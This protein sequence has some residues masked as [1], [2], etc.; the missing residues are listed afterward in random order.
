MIWRSSSLQFFEILCKGDEFSQRVE[1]LPLDVT[2]VLRIS[3]SVDAVKLLLVGH[4]HVS[5]QALDGDDIVLKKFSR[6]L[7][8]VTNLVFELL[9]VS[10]R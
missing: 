1:I 2:L 8:A 9:V 4:V 7:H 6:S 5:H 10:T 3:V